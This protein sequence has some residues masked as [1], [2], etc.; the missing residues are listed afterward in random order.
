MDIHQIIV[1]ASPGDAVTSTA[2]ALQ[3]L[4]RRVCPSAVYA[5]Y[6][7]PRL[8]REVLPLTAFDPVAEPDDLLIY[9]LSIGEPEIIRFLLGRPERLV[10]LY[11]NI[12]PAD[13]F[14]GLDPGFAA[15]L[16]GGRAE[17][18]VLRSRTDS[19]LA[20][21]SFN[22]REL[23]E[24][25]Y[26]DVSV[27]PLPVD[28]AGLRGLEPDPSTVD[29]LDALEGPL[30]LYVG[31]LL[32][33]KRPDLLLQAYSVLTTHLLPDVNLALLGPTR[34]ESYHDA[35]CTLAADLNLHRARITGWLNGEQLAA[36]YARADVFVTM[37]EH[38]GFCVPL[39]EAMS[40]D[41]P[42]LA[43]AF[44][45]IP[46]T[47]A[48]AGLLLPTDEDPLLAA[49]AMAELLTS[50]TLRAELRRRG[51]ERVVALDGEA[52]RATF[53]HHILR[54]AERSGR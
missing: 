1:S 17:L 50:G 18:E 25:G 27:S 40:F 44:G 9:H 51:R 7:D 28:I 19:A 48:G 34:L 36:Y 41:V 45:A 38:E 16:A 11:H 49:E 43:R 15:L 42:V 52:A 4:L 22:A 35:L 33:H 32:P 5:R 13:Y 24:L 39:L 14:L 10:L 30:L 37:S 46:E 23:E 21:S 53:L 12:T 20:V 29:A 8:H 3:Q 47:M 31:Q 6:V 54:V 2:L 26:R